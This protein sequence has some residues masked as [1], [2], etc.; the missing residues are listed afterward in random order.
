MACVMISCKAIRDTNYEL[1]IKY[2]SPDQVSTLLR[3]RPI[4]RERRIE[5]I[6]ARRLVIH[7]HDS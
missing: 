4:D 2:L 3:D 1:R 5:G 7:P 6:Y